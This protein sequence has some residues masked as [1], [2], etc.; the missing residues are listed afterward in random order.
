[1]PRPRVLPPIKKLNPRAFIEEHSDLPESFPVEYTFSLKTT[2]PGVLD[3]NRT[4]TLR[5]RMH[6][7]PNYILVPQPERTYNKVL[8]MVAEHFDQPADASDAEIEELAQDGV[9]ISITDAVKLAKAIKTRSKNTWRDK[10]IEVVIEKVASH[11]DGRVLL[12][13]RTANRRVDADGFFSTGA[14][15]GPELTQAREEE[16]PTLWIISATATEASATVAG[17]KFMYPSFVIPE[18]FPKLFMFNRG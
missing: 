17:Q 16:I 12:R 4:D 14:I 10:T 18:E 15:G 2:R 8:K 3:V 6:I 7:Y 5:P 11:Y 1:M 13:F 9:E